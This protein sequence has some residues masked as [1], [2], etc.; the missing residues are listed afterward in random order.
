MPRE[1]DD[2]LLLFAPA[3]GAELTAFARR[4]PHSL[5]FKHAHSGVNP[6]VA[7]GAYLLQA[8]EVACEL[9]NKERG[10]RERRP[11]TPER[12]LVIAAGVSN[13]GGTVLRALE[14]DQ[15]GWIS[16][17]LACEPNTMVAGRTDGLEIH[18]GG[19]RLKDA[20]IALCDYS[21]LHY[22]YQPC[23]VLA[24][25]DSA[26]PFFAASRGR[27]AAVLSLIHI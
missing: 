27:A 17:A 3:P 15:A 2:P 18:Y 8:I 14:R 16:G 24:E 25:G 26:A 7:W 4:E 23:A 12:T 21:G 9:I 1:P 11:L 6:E 22:L 10:S 5:L 20:G 13:G 19:R